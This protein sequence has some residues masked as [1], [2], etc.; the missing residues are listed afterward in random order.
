M[1]PSWYA[2]AV[3]VLADAIPPAIDRRGKLRAVPAAAQL[4]FLKRANDL[5]WP[6]GGVSILRYSVV[7]FLSV[8]KP[9]PTAKW[10]ICRSGSGHYLSSMITLLLHLL[11][12]LPVLFGDYRQLA[13]E[14]LALRQQLCVY[15]RTTTRPKLRATD[16][17][18][19][20]SAWPRSGSSGGSP[21]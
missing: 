21:S 20:G 1:V 5:R 14:N 9:H 16:R 13:I 8:A 10:L 11:R 18:F 4:R 15:K 7:A 17:L 19:S 3:S 6:S 2:H 12:L